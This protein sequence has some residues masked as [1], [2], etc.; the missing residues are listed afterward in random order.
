MIPNTNSKS[1]TAWRTEFQSKYI[2]YQN[3]EKWPDNAREKWTVEKVD[4]SPNNQLH[5]DSQSIIVHFCVIRYIVKNC[6]K[7]RCLFYSANVT[8]YAINC[9]G[10]EIIDYI[11]FIKCANVPFRHTDDGAQ[12]C[13]TTKWPTRNAIYAFT[14]FSY[15]KLYANNMLLCYSKYGWGHLSNE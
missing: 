11:V 14:A 9:Y 12:T 2:S 3:F 5:A 1:A 4:H 15:S 10:S 6:R 8:R 13:K 7:I